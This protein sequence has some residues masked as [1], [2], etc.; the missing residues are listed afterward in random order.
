MVAR[1][2]Q[3]RA[4]RLVQQ[5]RRLTRCLREKWRRREPQR[6]R[7]ARGPVAAPAFRRCLIRALEWNCVFESRAGKRMT[8]TLNG[9]RCEVPDG[10]SV[11]ALLDH[12]KM[13][14]NRVAIERNLDILPRH[15]WQETQ[16]QADDRYEIVRFVGGG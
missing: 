3:L 12:F 1:L 6:N 13:A 4:R 7:A 16:V 15:L 8:I 14:P 2:A 11:A 10:L 5:R 9:D